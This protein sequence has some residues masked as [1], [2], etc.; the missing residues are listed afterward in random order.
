M[1]SKAFPV[2]VDDMDLCSF[3]I[4]I[5]SSS[6]S[7]CCI[8]VENYPSLMIICSFLSRFCTSSSSIRCSAKASWASL[9]MS[10]LSYGGLDMAIAAYNSWG[11][12]IY[13]LSGTDLLRS[14][15]VL[16]LAVSFKTLPSLCCNN[17]TRIESLSVAGQYIL[18]Y[19]AVPLTL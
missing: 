15:F 16:F 2:I 4:N 11:E 12:L 8:I 13:H 1:I 5:C 6:S 9:E 17:A 19:R 18:S 10:V 7:C 14:I 3:S